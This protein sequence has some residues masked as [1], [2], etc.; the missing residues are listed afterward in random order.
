[1]A[2]MEASWLSCTGLISCLSTA[3]SST[4][5]PH[6][7]YSDICA[8]D[9]QVFAHENCKEEGH[10]T[11]SVPWRFMRSIDDARLDHT[12]STI[13]NLSRICAP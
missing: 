5:M 8:M 13:I 4:S 9:S 2:S 3:S 10:V 7:E 6:T 11:R 1:M 12:A